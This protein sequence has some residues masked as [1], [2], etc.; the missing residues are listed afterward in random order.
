MILK[1]QKRKLKIALN[2][3]D[4]VFLINSED[5]R[6]KQIKIYDKTSTTRQTYR[7]SNKKQKH[8]FY[9][10]KSLIFTSRSITT[11]SNLIS[12]YYKTRIEMR[13]FINHNIVIIITFIVF[14]FL[15]ESTNYSSSLKRE[16]DLISSIR[17]YLVSI[18]ILNFRKQIIRYTRELIFVTSSAFKEQDDSQSQN[19]REEKKR[20]RSQKIDRKRDLI[21]FLI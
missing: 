17:K 20:D 14:D 2:T 7:K 16:N 1:T 6:V 11:I 18:I 21:S 10:M 8:S 15:D 19:N 4:D 3:N 12:D 9:L 13:S 5:E